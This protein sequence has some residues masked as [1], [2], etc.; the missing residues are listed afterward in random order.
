VPVC[1]TCHD[2]FPDDTVSCPRDGTTLVVTQ[3]LAEATTL[4][5]MAAAPPAT[6]QAPSGSF[7]SLVGATLANRYTI[8]RRIG[9]GGM[10]AV[11]EARHAV[12]GKRVAVK[13]LLEKFLAKS[14]FVARLLQEAR[15]ASSIGHEN[16]VD[17]IDFGTTDDGRSF[18][19][20]EFLD[21]ESLAQLLM[22]E[23]PLPVERS[24]RLGRQVASALSAAHAKGIV[25]RDVK[26]E[27]VYI[28]RRGDADFVKVVDFGISKAVRQGQGD[29]NDDGLQSLRLTHTGLLLGTPLYMSPEQARG[30]EDLDHRVDIWA[31]GVMLYECLTGEVPFR[32]NNYLG[33]ISQVLNHVPVPPSQLRPELGIPES[34]EAVVMRAMEKDRARR[35]ATMSDL[36]GELERL[37][38]GDQ[39]VGL[40]TLEAAAVEV[41]PRAIVHRWHLGLAAGILLVGGA[42][43]VLTR[44]E[45]GPP[46]KVGRAETAPAAVAA[47]VA[48]PASAASS[49]SASA[50]AVVAGPPSAA[51][52]AGATVPPAAAVETSPPS[53]ESP[54]SATSP[55]M[56][57]AQPAGTLASKKKRPPPRPTRHPTP[58]SAATPS[59]PESVGI[60][61]SVMR[62]V[63]SPHSREGYPDSR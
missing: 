15:L 24:L 48:G 56:P 6:A 10:G 11:Y 49:G 41:V 54:V 25:H 36:E 3:T 22:R 58:A 23:A 38:A 14:D 7:D 52:R 61:E 50:G 31:L 21:G 9:E 32:A 33:I 35:T 43:L 45:A 1:P 46:A 12:I 39:N 8:L 26:P 57:V 55:R 28:V 18:V 59:A 4:P 51:A 5:E 40:T 30:A 53:G 37:L 60:P 2:S 29:S 44:P 13:V 17:V 16:I 34:V 63:L 42:V 47:S 20:M 19:V 27:N 62:G